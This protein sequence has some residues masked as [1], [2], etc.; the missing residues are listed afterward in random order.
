M[1]DAGLVPSMK[2]PNRMPTKAMPMQAP[3][4]SFISSFIGED[5]GFL[6]CGWTLSPANAR[7]FTFEGALPRQI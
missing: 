4:E 5:A 3:V 1:N 2:A 6:Q 7:V